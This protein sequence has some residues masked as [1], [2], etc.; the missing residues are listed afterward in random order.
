MI[1]IQLNLLTYFPLHFSIITKIF[2][3][4][5]PFNVLSSQ[6]LIKESSLI[7]RRG[8]R[9]GLKRRKYI[10]N[11][12]SEI[13]YYVYSQAQRHWGLLK[14]MQNIPVHLS[15]P[16]KQLIWLAICEFQ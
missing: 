13:S 10:H 8:I 14:L 9:P 3:L 7:E 11:T 16:V 1:L 2:E 5:Y 4:L 12:K 15:V 6:N